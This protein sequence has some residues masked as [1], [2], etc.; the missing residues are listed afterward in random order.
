M[1][2]R[3]WFTSGP[4]FAFASTSGTAAAAATTVPTLSS[5]I[6][7]PLAIRFLPHCSSSFVETV[8]V[9]AGSRRRRP[10]LRPFGLPPF[11]LSMPLCDEDRQIVEKVEALLGEK[12]EDDDFAKKLSEALHNIDSAIDL[13]G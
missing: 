2:L 8:D 11:A 13:F 7:S 1:R 9:L 4:R 6:S 10:L 12:R 5:T 3:P